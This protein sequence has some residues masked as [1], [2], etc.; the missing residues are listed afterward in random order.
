MLFVKMMFI[1]LLLRMQKIVFFGNLFI[2]Q[3]VNCFFLNSND[4]V[5]CVVCY[6][7]YYMNCV[8]LFLFK[9]FLC[10]FVWFCVVCSCVQE[11]KL[12]VCYILNVV[13][14][15]VDVEDEEMFDEE[16]DDFY[17]ID[18]ECNSFDGDEYYY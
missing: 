9:K 14:L 4:F 5:D 6:N 1:V 12:E 11:C 7:M 8:K 13:D 15:N 17:V 16:D 2:E 3:L 18:M 10:G